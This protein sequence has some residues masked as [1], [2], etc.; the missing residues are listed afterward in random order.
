MTPDGSSEAALFRALWWAVRAHWQERRKVVRAPYLIHPLRVAALLISYGLPEEPYAVAA[1]LHDT[2]EHGRLSLESIRQEFGQPVASL[3][4]GVSPGRAG[5]AWRAR[6]EASID[7]LRAAPGPVVILACADK[8][9]NLLSLTED[10]RRLGDRAWK[11]MRRSPEE[12]AWYYTSL[13][14]M[15]CAR[16]EAGLQNPLLAEFCELAGRL[17]GS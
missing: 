1:L 6:K 15:F 9:D 12:I 10:E 2:V 7:R 17:F 16:R 5:A 4:E 11:R 3:V 13:A 14:D 8:L